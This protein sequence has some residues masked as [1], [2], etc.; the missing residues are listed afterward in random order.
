MSRNKLYRA[1]IESCVLPEVKDALEIIARG[2]QIRVNELI[3][4]ILNK[5]LRAKR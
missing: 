1:R 2:K 3:R 5:Y 4:Q